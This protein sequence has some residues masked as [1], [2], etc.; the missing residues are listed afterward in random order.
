MALRNLKS[1]LAAGDLASEAA[2]DLTY[3]KGTAYD[4]PGQGFSNEPFIKGGIDLGGTTSFNAITGGFIR[5]GALMHA[6][7]LLQDTARIGKFLVS[8]RGITFIAKQVGLQKSNPKISEPSVGGI[9]GSPA[10]HRTYN[11][12]INTLAQVVGQG[13]GLHVNRQGLGPFAKDG[14]KDEERF[15]EN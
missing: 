12:G 1:D 6:E 2:S 3:G 4:R 10:N 15:L 8:N 14:Y 5:G 11:L 7:R 9:L 13:T